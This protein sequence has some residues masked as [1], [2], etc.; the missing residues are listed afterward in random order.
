MVLIADRSFQTHSRL[1]PFNYLSQSMIWKRERS[2]GAPPPLHIARLREGPTCFIKSVPL[3]WKTRVKE[4]KK[5]RAVLCMVC[6]KKN[7]R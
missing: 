4:E 2:F 5:S 1:R 3:S 7:S 6:E